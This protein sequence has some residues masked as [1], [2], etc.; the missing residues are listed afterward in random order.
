M[1]RVSFST[2]WLVAKRLTQFAAARGLSRS[3][4]I[5]QFVVEGLDARRP[6]PSDEELAKRSPEKEAQR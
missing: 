5:Q 6:L 2:D 3:S 1:H 4:L